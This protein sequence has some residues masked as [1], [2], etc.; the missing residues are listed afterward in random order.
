MC[1]WG[2]ERFDPNV[3]DQKALN[4]DVNTLS[5]KWKPR[6]TTKQSK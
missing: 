3:I 6:R 2:L 5:G 1:I 4:D